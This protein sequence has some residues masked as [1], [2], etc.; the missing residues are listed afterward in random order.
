MW[1]VQDSAVEWVGPGRRVKKRELFLATP[2]EL[3]P[4]IPIVMGGFFKNCSK[5]RKLLDSMGTLLRTMSL[6]GLGGPPGQRDTC[7]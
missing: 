6:V 2:F 3:L 4:D 7:V 5:L 1:F